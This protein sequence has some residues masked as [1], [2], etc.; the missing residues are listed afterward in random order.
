MIMYQFLYESKRVLKTVKSNDGH[1]QWASIIKLDLLF[2][3]V[4]RLKLA[5]VWMQHT[6]TTPSNHY[7]ITSWITMSFCMAISRFKMPSNCFF[8][9][10]FSL[11]MSNVRE[12]PLPFHMCFICLQS[13]KFDWMTYTD[14]QKSKMK[15]QSLREAEEWEQKQYFG[16]TNRFELFVFLYSSLSCPVYA[17]YLHCK[18][19][20]AAQYWPFIKSPYMAL[21]MCMQSYCSNSS[22]MESSKKKILIK[23]P[24]TFHK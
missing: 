1:L 18:R 24:N 22:E 9:A 3:E 17:M 13:I 11:L 10:F 6:Q 16:S 23:L 19:A 20:A 2:A 12:Q 4:G 5:C 8:P 7:S 21:S 15:E 14:T